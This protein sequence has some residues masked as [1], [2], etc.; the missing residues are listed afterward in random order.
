MNSTKESHIVLFITQA[1]SDELVLATL[2][3]HYAQITQC[4]QLKDVCKLLVHKTPKVFLMTGD[5]LEKSLYNY[6]RSL[7]AVSQYDICEHRVVALIPRQSEADAYEA[8]KAK[9]IDDY[10]VSRPI[11]EMHRIVLICEHLLIELGIKPAHSPL[12][13]AKINQQ[14]DQFAEPLKQSVQKGLIR[15]EELKHAFEH[16]V[17]EIDNALELAASKIQLNQTVNLDI[18]RLKETLSSIRS[19][20]IRPELLKLQAKTLYLLEQILDLNHHQQEDEAETLDE[21]EEKVEVEAEVDAAKKKPKEQYAFNRLYQQNVDPNELLQESSNIPTILLVEDDIISSQL[22]KMLLANYSVHLETVANG[23]QAFA[24]LTSKK[25]NLVLMDVNL[26]DTNG[27]Y[28]LDQATSGNSINKDT[29][30]VMLSGNKNK[31][32]VAKALERG[33]KGYII[34]PLDKSTVG[35][36][37]AR[38][39]NKNNKEK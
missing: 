21:N 3:K 33:A 11:Y 1:E 14:I 16:S 36:L 30:I 39:L 31:A 7:D 19:D 34:K 12:S 24:H 8:Y 18:K 17:I 32:T 25:Y 35:K 9:I 29:P 10:M 13:T 5:N 23:R 26:P 2:K 38:F 28:I 37:F 20:E 6:Y 15:K 4:T 27:I 22:T